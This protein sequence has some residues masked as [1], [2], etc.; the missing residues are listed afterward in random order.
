MS[1]GGLCSKRDAVGEA[2]QL[3]SLQQRVRQGVAQWQRLQRVADQLAQHC[4]RQPGGGR[5]DWRE[6]LLQ[7]RIVIHSAALRVHHLQPVVTHAHLADGAY[8]FAHGQLFLLAGIKI[9][10]AQIQ[11]A[12]VVPQTANQPTARAEGHF[13]VRDDALHLR[14]HAG[15]QRGDRRQ[16]GLV[17][18]AQRQVQQQVGAMM[19]AELGEFAQR[20]GGDF[21]RCAQLQFSPAIVLIVSSEQNY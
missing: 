9:Q 20:G 7:R 1:G 13:A 6:A 21:C 2:G 17:L 3:H 19:D 12:A 5:V 15:L 14:I 8:L 4:L 18:V 10:E 16:M 11:F